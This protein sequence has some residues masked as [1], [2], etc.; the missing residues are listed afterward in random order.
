MNVQLIDYTGYGSRHPADHAANVLI[1]TKNTRLKM[2]PDGAAQIERWDAARKL[3]ELT[4]MAATIPSSHEFVHYTFCITGVSRAFTH[5][6][7]RTRTGSY[8]QQTMRVLDVSGWSY[9]TG[10]TLH[11]FEGT[12]ELW[13]D[14]MKTIDL[15]YQELIAKG[16]SIEDARG[17]LPTNI[18]T[19]IVA[20][21]NLRTLC[22]LVQ[23]RSSS[24][25]QGEYRD[26]LNGMRAEAIRVH[27]FVELFLNSTP[28]KAADDLEALV[29]QHMPA[30]LRITAVKL[31]DKLRSAV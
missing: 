3:E 10:P 19:N 9:T 18:Q 11:N 14:T 8:A 16:V 23:K 26:V 15:A 2:E 24:R 20:G 25:V 22:E 21:F 12:F 28:V 17:I 6:F 13:E 30:E 4:Y 7:V 29:L 31:I 1:F 5:Q 27:P